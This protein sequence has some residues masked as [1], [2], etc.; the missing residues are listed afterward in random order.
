MKMKIQNFD[1]EIA[2]GD[3]KSEKWRTWFHNEA[4]VANW[5][6]HIKKTDACIEGGG[7]FMNCYLK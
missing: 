5:K 6:D 7:S 4:D 3:K 2:S 1:D